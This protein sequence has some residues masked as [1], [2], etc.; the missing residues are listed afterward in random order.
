MKLPRMGKPAYLKPHHVQKDD[1]LEIV[2]EPYVQSAEDSKYGRARGYAVVRLIRTGELYTCG[3]NTTTWDRMLDAFG[4]DAG[5]WKGK[6]MKVTLETQTIR[7]E[8]KQVMFG[9]PY[10]E[11]QRPLTET[12]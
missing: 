4:E 1:L 7:G 9:K 3:F 5:L 10:T 12:A 8:Q 6:R 2:E 11:P